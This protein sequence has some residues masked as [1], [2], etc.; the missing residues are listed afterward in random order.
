MMTAI[1]QKIWKREVVPK[2]WKDAVMEVLFKNK[3]Q[4]DDCNT[5]GVFA[6][7]LKPV[8]FYHE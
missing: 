5:F 1:I 8:K 4:K 3:G 2:G 7:L 6:C